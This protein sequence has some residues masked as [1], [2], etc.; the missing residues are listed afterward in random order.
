M[1]G[2]ITACGSALIAAIVSIVTLVLN[3]KWQKE[4]RT[5]DRIT[6]LSRKIDNVQTALTNHINSDAEMD[7]RQARRRIIDFSDECRR[8]TLHS[9]EHFDNV[10]EDISFYERYCG[11]HPK[12]ENRKAEQ[13]IKFITDVYD[14]CKREN[15]FI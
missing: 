2:I 12:F 10:L 4:D 15:K 14:A 11:E 5:A 8:G 1:I 6:E 7:A 3:R 9:V 13:S